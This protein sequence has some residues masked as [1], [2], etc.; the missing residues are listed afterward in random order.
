[1]N[2]RIPIEE[3]VVLQIKLHYPLNWF[4]SQI[5]FR[6]DLFSEDYC[7]I[8]FDTYTR[9]DNWVSFTFHESLYEMKV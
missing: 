4:P 1:M 9:F 2:H 8:L 3:G 6:S 7:D 5:L